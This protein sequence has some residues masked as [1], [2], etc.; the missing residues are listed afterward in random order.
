MF[1]VYTIEDN[2]LE[3]LTNSNFLN[4]IAEEV[5]FEEIVEEKII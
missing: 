3:E 2:Y 1:I 4:S 5:E